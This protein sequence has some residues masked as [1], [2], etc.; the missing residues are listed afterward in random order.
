MQNCSQH[1]GA[2]CLLWA[3]IFSSSKWRWLCWNIFYLLR[4]LY[5]WEQWDFSGF[6]FD[7][8][9]D[10]ISSDSTRLRSG[11]EDFLERWQTGRPAITG[12]FIRMYCSMP[13]IPDDRKLLCCQD[14]AAEIEGKS[15]ISIFQFESHW[16]ELVKWKKKEKKKSRGK[17]R[18]A[19][20]DTL[21]FL[22]PSPLSFCK[23]SLAAF[24]RLWIQHWIR[25]NGLLMCT[26]DNYTFSINSKCK[27]KCNLFLFAYHCNICSHITVFNNPFFKSVNTFWNI[28]SHNNK[29]IALIGLH[30]SLN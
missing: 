18:G 19:N 17:Q 30:T 4:M 2:R 7:L 3:L 6:F 16:N 29:I 22:A 13:F 14:A 20:K 10:I 12:F 1:K 24:L 26:G 11:G 5:N 9:E 8:I 27:A 25:N 28:N 21:Y 15:N 23:F